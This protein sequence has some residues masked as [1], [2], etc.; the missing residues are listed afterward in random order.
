MLTKLEQFRDPQLDTSGDV[1]GFYEREFYTFS[2]FSSF[3]VEWRGRI[4]PTSEHAYQAAHFFE[5]SP[6]LVEEIF[7]ARSA[8]DALKIA[9]T[10]ANKAPDNWEKINVKIMKDICKQKLLQ[11]SYVQQKLLQTAD[12]LLV[13]DSPK[14]NFWGWGED[15]KGRN[16]LGKIWMQLR[17]WLRKNPNLV[18]K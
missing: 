8:H 4:W 18:I 1:V 9:K 6:E 3:Q 2:N 14:D 10:N 11:H 12:L 7:K 15:R 16:E 17:E 5:T 13:E